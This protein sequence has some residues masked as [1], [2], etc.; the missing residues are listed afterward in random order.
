[1]DYQH[2]Q[3]PYS[4]IERINMKKEDFHHLATQNVLLLMVYNRFVKH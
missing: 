1:M 2:V 3:V 4:Q